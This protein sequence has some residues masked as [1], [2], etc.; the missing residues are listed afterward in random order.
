MKKFWQIIACS[1]LVLTNCLGGIAQAQN[2]KS[3]VEYYYQGK[4]I[5]LDKAVNI[6][7]NYDV[8]FFD[9]YHD[10]KF[11]HEAELSFLQ[12]MYKQNKD[13]ILS[14]EMFEKDIQPVMDKYLNSEITEI[15]FID[16]SRP[17]ENYQT[18][19]KPLVEFAK[20]KDIFVL[21]SNIPRRIANQ[22]TKVGD[23]DLIEAND[24]QYLPQ[25]HLVEFEAYYNKF[26]NYMS[27]GDES[28]HMVMTPE[29]IEAFYKAQCLKDD[30]MAESIVEFLNEHKDTKVLHV[31]GAFH[32]D[33]HL[34]VV[35]KV[36]KLNP[37]LKTVVI[38]PIEAKDYEKVKNN[39][40]KDTIIMTF[41]RK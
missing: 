34:G 8:V 22:Y 9:E 11:I 38:T 30:T 6:S 29:R 21:A 19:Y 24:K 16:N 20:E 1:G 17:W 4:K 25:I 36:N 13:M 15:E 18:D 40:G 37:D 14:M 26:K 27:T 35:E 31:Q 41:V 28:S 2:E 5:D 23:L 32:G 33:E 10:Q 7:Q 3:D 39:Y 12:E